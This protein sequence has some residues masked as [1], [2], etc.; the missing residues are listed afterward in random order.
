MASFHQHVAASTA[1]GVG[2]GAAA[3][4][5]MQIDWATCVI[6]GGL[7][8]LAGM[9]PDLDAPT[10]QPVREVFGLAATLAPVLLIR[11]LSAGVSW[12]YDRLVGGEVELTP[13]QIVVVMAACYFTVRFAAAWLL[14]RLTVHRGMWHS[15]P[16][17][18]I[19]AAIAF[20]L[21]D[22]PDPM[23]R[24]LLAGGPFLG[25]MSHLVMDEIWSLRVSDGDVQLKKSAGTAMK[26]FSS[27]IPATLTAYVILL[28]LCWA[29]LHDPVVD[30][31]IAQLQNRP[32]TP[33]IAAEVMDQVRR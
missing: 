33:R 4:L 9:L 10:G 30:D 26:F 29:L 28:G 23:T 22:A 8:G 6:A 15:I 2:Y 25:F 11:Q 31:A 18:L 32:A 16:A 7:T 27:S 12:T 19:T 21:L 3:W 20:L 5:G 13:A 1:L 24:L 14:D 17:A